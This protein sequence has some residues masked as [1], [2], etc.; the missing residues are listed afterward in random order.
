MVGPALLLPSR[1][2]K[3]SVIVLAADGLRQNRLHNS[4]LALA[5]SLPKRTITDHEFFLSK[6]QL[7]PFFPG[8]TEFFL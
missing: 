3:L 6:I 1:C 8:S 7:V 2:T 5:F 4:F